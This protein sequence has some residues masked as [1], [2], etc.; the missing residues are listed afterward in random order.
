[1]TY[2]ETMEKQRGFPHLQPSADMMTARDPETGDAAKFVPGPGSCDQCCFAPHN[3][4]PDWNWGCIPCDAGG[5]PDQ[6]NGVWVKTEKEKD[7][8][9]HSE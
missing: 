4:N 6:Q 9:S 8:A 1:M 2:T 5:R 3:R 7:D